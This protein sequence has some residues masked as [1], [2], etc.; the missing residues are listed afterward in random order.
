MLV[1]ESIP[2]AVARGLAAANFVVACLSS[3][4]NKSGWVEA[5]LAATVMRQ[6]KE[7]TERVLPVRLDAVP[8]PESIHYL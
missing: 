5:E 6:F 4:A 1:G 8:P 3:A 7:R 2:S